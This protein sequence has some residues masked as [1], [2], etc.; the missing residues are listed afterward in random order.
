[1]CP[2][3]LVAAS[4]AFVGTHFALS[5]P[6]RAPLVGRLGENGFRGLYSIVSL[7]TFVWAVLAFRA[8]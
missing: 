8:A 7:A 2:S 6:V 5:H 1:M 3:T 4:I